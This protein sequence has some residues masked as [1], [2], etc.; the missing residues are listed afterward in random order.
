VTFILTTDPEP[1]FAATAVNVVPAQFDEA[2]PI[3]PNSSTPGTLAEFGEVDSFRL[4]LPTA[5]LLTVRTTG[6]TDT[7]GELLDAQDE[8]L[9]AN[10]DDFDRNFVISRFLPAGTYVVRVSGFGGSTGDYTLVARFQK[11]GSFVP[12]DLVIYTVDD[13]DN[14][15]VLGECRS[16]AGTSDATNQ[17]TCAFLLGA[18]QSRKL[19]ALVFDRF[20]IDIGYTLDILPAVLQEVRALPEEP[21]S[22]GNGNQCKVCK[23]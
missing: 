18:A 2:I 4:D 15:T 7:V 12:F 13:N 17:T 16:N 3:A 9:A 6:S 11:P 1:G 21:H 22:P 23:K 20:N 14:D 8:L 19:R 5:G 10:D